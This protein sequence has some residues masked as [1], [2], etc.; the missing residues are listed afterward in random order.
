MFDRSSRFDARHGTVLHIDM[1]FSN[2]VTG[3]ARQAVRS[4]R[5]LLCRAD[6]TVCPD[7]LT[8]NQIGAGS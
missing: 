3:L 1:R 4:W 8:S 5:P 2:R 7:S 6:Q